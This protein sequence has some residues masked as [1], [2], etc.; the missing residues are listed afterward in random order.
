M[1]SRMGINKFF[2]E[3]GAPVVN[4][5]WS[6]GGV[7]EARRRVFLRVWA[8]DERT[9]GPFTRYAV[10]GPWLFPNKPSHGYAERKRHI[11]LI[12]SGYEA[13]AIICSRDAPGEGAIRS[14]E[15][16]KVLRLG[17]LVEE[18]NDLC[19]RVIGEAFAS[20]LRA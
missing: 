3:L 19:A 7:N 13:F 12:R 2:E 18:G 9:E 15:S 16:Q 20:E 14:F 10:F 17:E 1:A 11:D 6:W 4:R 8:D 5:R